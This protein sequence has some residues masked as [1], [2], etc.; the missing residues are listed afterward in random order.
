MALSRFSTA[1]AED[2]A[3]LKDASKNINTSKATVNWIRVFKSWALTRNKP[4]DPA[5]Y[6]IAE[7]DETLQLFYAEVKKQNGSDYEP[8]CLAN[9]QRAIDR[10]LRDSGCMY[11]IIRDRDFIESRKVLEG[12]ARQLRHL[13]MGKKPN[14]SRSLS[15]EDEKVLWDCGQLGDHSPNAL[16]N[17]VFMFLQQHFGW[18]GRQETYETQVGDLKFQTADDGTE[19][20]VFYE[21]IV[22]T[23][24]SGLT[25]KSRPVPPKMFATNT[26]RC[27]I[28]IIRSYLARRPLEL[29]KCGPLYLT[30]IHNP[31]SNIW[32]K[33]VR[34][35]INYT[36]SFMKRMKENSPLATCGKKLTNHSTR[37]TLVKKLKQAK[38]PGSEIIKITGH[39]SEKGLQAYD[40]GDEEEMRSI[41]DAIAGHCQPSSSSSSTKRSFEMISNKMWDAPAAPIFNF[42]NCN[43]YFNNPPLP[44]EGQRQQQ[45]VKRKRVIYSSDDSQSQ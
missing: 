41:S 40:S 39:S 12:K 27:P 37:K 28:K 17:T 16:I 15:K 31:I 24:Q 21:G 38:V 20:I 25:D 11:S 9:M 26:E 4:I 19:Y 34:M 33:N 30:P 10:H 13:G 1:A 8:S 7:L 23:R 29:R 35:S 3:I 45:I 22:K 2:I 32:Y 6:T 14:K 5:R 18:R 42:S 43:V 44:N 36:S